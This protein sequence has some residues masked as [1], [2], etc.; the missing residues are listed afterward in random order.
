MGAGMDGDGDQPAGPAIQGQAPMETAAVQ[1]QAPAPP[2]AA[3]ADVLTLSNTRA[4]VT[5]PWPAGMS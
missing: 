3:A 5:D 1:F 2:R 4:P